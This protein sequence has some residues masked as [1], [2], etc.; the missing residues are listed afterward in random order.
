MAG[1]QRE[2]RIRRPGDRRRQRDRE[3]LPGCAE[4]LF[5]LERRIRFEAYDE[6]D[7]IHKADE[8][9]RE[10]QPLVA[11]T[12]ADVFGVGLSR[13]VYG[14][15]NPRRYDERVF[16]LHADP[17]MLRRV[18]SA[19]RCKDEAETDRNCHFGV[20][21]ILHRNSAFSPNYDCFLSPNN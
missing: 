18:C 1:L 13:I 9:A 12:G 15:R 7:R 16:P 11:R 19:R 3:R 21:A 4:P 20:I 17:L 6:R 8:R 5:A 10:A 14:D 2:A